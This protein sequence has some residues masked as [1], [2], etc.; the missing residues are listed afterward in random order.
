MENDQRKPLV[1]TYRL[2]FSGRIALPA[3]FPLFTIQLSH[4]SVE[5]PLVSQEDQEQIRQTIEMFE[6]ITQ[7]N[8]HDCQS[9]EILKD[10]YQKIGQLSDML[11]VARQLAGTYVQLGQY[12]SAMLEY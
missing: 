4:M 9:L 3:R 11:R 7:A 2:S 1:I 10:A 5:P 8:P 6:V 12:S